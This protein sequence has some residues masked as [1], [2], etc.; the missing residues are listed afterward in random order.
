M[1]FS[2]LNVQ[3][4]IQARE[5]SKQNLQLA[6]AI[7]GINDDMACLISDLTPQTLTQIIQINPPLL[8]PRQETWWWSRFITALRDGHPAEIEAIIGHGSTTIK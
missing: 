3:Y 4:L 5:L 1:D 6:A 7:L 2:Q 8:I